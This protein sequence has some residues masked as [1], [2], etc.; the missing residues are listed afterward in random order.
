MDELGL[1][2]VFGFDE[3]FVGAG[4]AVYR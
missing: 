1:E 4:F 3:D 2:R